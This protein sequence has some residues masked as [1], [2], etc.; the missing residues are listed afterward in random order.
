MSGPFFQNSHENTHE[1]DSKSEGK[2]FR[3]LS[4]EK[5]YSS[6]KALKDHVKH[7]HLDSKEIHSCTVSW[8]V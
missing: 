3:C 6:A 4:C 8:I 1:A 7:S 2:K 5:S